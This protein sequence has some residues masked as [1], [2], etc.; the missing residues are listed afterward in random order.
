MLQALSAM[1]TAV[2]IAFSTGWKL[3]FVVSCFAPLL[4][5]TGLF[6]GRKQNHLA[7]SKQNSSFIEQAEQ[8]TNR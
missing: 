5:L 2:V 6:Q 4:I 1:I 7:K 8:V 3:A